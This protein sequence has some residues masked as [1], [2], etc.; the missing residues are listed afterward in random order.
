MKSS[1]TVRDMCLIGVMAAVI[2]L[3]TVVPR[4][5]IPLGYAHLGDGAIMLAGFYGGK[6]KGALASAIGSALADGLGGFAIW[7]IPTFIIKYMMGRTAYSNAPLLS[8]KTLLCFLGTAAWLVIGYTLA[9]ALLY[10]SLATGLTSTPGL[11]YEA[12]INLVAAYAVGICLEK[13]GFQR[14]MNA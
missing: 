12:A 3:L 9:G 4:V 2:F 1:Y 7:I 8:F 5:P 10:G 13:A 11:L 14:L 6:K